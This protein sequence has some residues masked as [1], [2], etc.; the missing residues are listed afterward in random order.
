[1]PQTIDSAIAVA[2]SRG[3]V[4]MLRRR[5]DDRSFPGKWCFPG[6]QKDAEDATLEAAALREL[7]EETGLEGL[8]PWL[9][10]AGDSPLPKRERVY[11]IS[12]FS[13]SVA[14][15]EVV[16]SDESGPRQRREAPPQLHR[17]RRRCRLLLDLRPPHRGQGA[18]GHRPSPGMGG[19]GCST[20]S[21]CC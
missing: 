9:L 7:R 10:Y 6:G 12:A 3:R 19:I 13:M 15:G 2:R 1:M 21:D 5:L 17:G 14:P 18:G 8:R 4:L 16:L 20:C 11:R